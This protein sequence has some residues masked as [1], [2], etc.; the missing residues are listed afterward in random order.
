[1]IATQSLLLFLIPFD[2]KE[3]RQPLA[4]EQSRPAMALLALWI[5]LGALE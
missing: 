5:R 1:M 2:S 4:L 3:T